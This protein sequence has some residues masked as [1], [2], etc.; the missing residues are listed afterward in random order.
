MNDIEKYLQSIYTP[1]NNIK[2]Y[3]KIYYQINKQRLLDYNKKRYDDRL[4]KGE[5]KFT[6]GDY[7]IKF[8]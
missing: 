4:K 3:R 5:L 8:N 7:I 6:R 1:K 2:I